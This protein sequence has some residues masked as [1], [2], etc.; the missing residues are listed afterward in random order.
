MTIDLIAPGVERG[1]FE[2]LAIGAIIGGFLFKLLDY[3]VNRKGGYLRKPSTAMNYWRNQARVRLE[4]VLGSMHRTQ[5]FGKLSAEVKDKLLT[6]ILIRDIPAKSCLYRAEDPATN[7]YIIESGELE[8]SDPQH[9]GK[10]FERL[11]KHDVFGRMSFITGL[12]RATEA[13]TVRDTKLLIIPREPFMD[14]LQDSDELRAIVARSIADDEVKT[15]LQQRHGLQPK[16]AAAW[17]EQALTSLAKNGRYAPPIR[18]EAVADDLIGLLK[19]DQ[20]L[21]FFSELSDN[22]L[23]RIADRL[24][25]KTNPQGYNYYHL[26]QPADRLYLLRRGKVFLF[27]PDDHSRKPIVVQ[28]GNSF[29][30]LSFFTEGA[31]ALTAVAHE[32]AEISV[33]HH[34][35]F[36]ELLDECPELR[37]HLSEYLRRKR[38]AQ[39]LT[40]KHKLDAKRAASWMQKAA[41]SVRG[42]PDLPIAGRD[43]PTG[44]GTSGYSHGYIPW[45]P[46]RRHP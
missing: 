29:G 18:R 38:I 1:H 3:L 4:A 34:W 21:E 35:D 23:Q 42:W 12:Y 28:A 16:D 26:G 32:E 41:R 22:T 10:V 36:E 27:D 46:G 24:I 14:L 20:R 9:G 33:L 40:Q 13:H 2:D 6:L 44:R 19:N 7:L 25:H 5:P 15:Y 39:Y 31:H 8:L 11:G 43:D 37:A 17:R 30:A 45:Y